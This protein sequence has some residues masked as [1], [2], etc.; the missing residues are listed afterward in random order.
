MTKPTRW[1]FGVTFWLNEEQYT[2]LH[3]I[4][5]FETEKQGRNVTISSIM[6]DLVQKEISQRRDM[7]FIGDGVVFGVDGLYYRW[8]VPYVSGHENFE[9]EQVT[10]E[11]YDLFTGKTKLDGSSK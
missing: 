6:R 9:F 5:N 7:Y 2:M 10:K 4:S 8:I 11:E 1:P 3:K